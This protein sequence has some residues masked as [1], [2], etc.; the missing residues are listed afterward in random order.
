MANTVATPEQK[1]AILAEAN[2]QVRAGDT[3]AAAGRTFNVVDITDQLTKQVA[4]SKATL[5]KTKKLT[6]SQKALAK[7]YREEFFAEY[8]A[9]EMAPEKKA[10]ITTILGP[11][12]FAPVDK[13]EAECQQVET[14]LALE[15]AGEG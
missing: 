12:F 9:G 8:S 11:K 13:F 1:K 2:T 6:P 4:K 7:Q 10:L 14:Y 15:S 3:A 5:I